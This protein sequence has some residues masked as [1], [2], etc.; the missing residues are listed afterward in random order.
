MS[1]VSNRETT[2]QIKQ[3][4]TP[5]LK[6]F[7]NRLRIVV[8]T[9]VVPFVLVIGAGNQIEKWIY[10]GHTFLWVSSMTVVES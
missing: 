4:V 6:A 3:N 9:D 7:K 10:C 8:D 1:T 5:H 2:K